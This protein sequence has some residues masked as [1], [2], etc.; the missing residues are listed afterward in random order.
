[1]GEAG[2]GRWGLMSRKKTND[3]C[4]LRFQ[5]EGEGSREQE[6]GERE[7]RGEGRRGKRKE[8]RGKRQ[9]KAFQSRRAQLQAGS[10]GGVRR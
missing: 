9:Q 7:K 10:G 5:K 1:M 2:W 8:K 4:K 6:K 3:Q